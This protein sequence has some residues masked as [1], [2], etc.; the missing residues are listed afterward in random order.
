MRPRLAIS[1]FLTGSS[2]EAEVIGRSWLGTSNYEL[3]LGAYK[4]FPVSVYLVQ[5][6][7]NAHAEPNLLEKW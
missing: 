1:R 2:P 4:S 7:T 5:I 3:R 6:R